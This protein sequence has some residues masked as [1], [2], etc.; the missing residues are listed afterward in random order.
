MRSDSKLI[1]GVTLSF[2]SICVG[3]PATNYIIIKV[4]ENVLGFENNLRIIQKQEVMMFVY[5]LNKA[6]EILDPSL[7]GSSST[8][9]CKLQ[10]DLV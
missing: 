7:C 1:S 6:E 3:S 9:L 8:N 5:W 4:N 10:V 2:D